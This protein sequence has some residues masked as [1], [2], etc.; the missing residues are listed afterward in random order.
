MY[1]LQ[2]LKEV[3]LVR[4]LFLHETA[5]LIV[6]PQEESKNHDTS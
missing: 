4:T 2:R 5:L 1:D 6:C 3:S